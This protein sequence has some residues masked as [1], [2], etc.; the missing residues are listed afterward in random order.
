MRGSLVRRGKNRYAIVL[1]M[2]YVTDSATGRRKRKQKWVSFRGPKKGPG[3]AEEKLTE[4]VRAVN[5]DE[6]VEPTKLTLGE[7]VARWVAKFAVPSLRRPATCALYSCIVRTHL[8]D[9]PLALMPVQKVRA[10][11]IEEYY[12]SL[13]AAPASIRVHHAVISQALRAAVRDRVLTSNPAKEVTERPRVTTD[14]AREQ[15][16]TA[17]E[18]RA[19]LAEAKAHAPQ[20]AA[21]FGLALDTGARQSELLGLTWDRVSLDKAEIAIDR[22]LTRDSGAFGPTKSGRARQVIIDARTVT[23]LRTHKRAQAT[24][25]L[26]NRTT[27]DDRGL[28][29]A[30]EARDLQTPGAALG[31]PLSR[32]AVVCVFEKLTKAAKVRRIRFHGLR[33]TCATLLLA[34]G[35]PVHNVSE[36]LGHAKA[37]MTLNVYGH[38][39][40]GGQATAAARIGTVLHG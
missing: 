32:S 11:D 30:K 5:R 27:Y 1:D 31:Q 19:F 36:R 3:G 13:D 18:A 33:H 34:A 4:L 7:L 28:V 25:K 37:S 20:A 39:L 24:L 40:P 22:Q 14:D 12:A 9:S 29:F 17:T 21:L 16:W 8:T 15:C 38:A 2:G 6:F 26:A 35:E 23:L 10:T